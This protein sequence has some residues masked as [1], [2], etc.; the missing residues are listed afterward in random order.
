MLFVDQLVIVNQD[1]YINYCYLLNI[2]LVLFVIC[3]MTQIFNTLLSKNIYIYLTHLLFFFWL[4]SFKPLLFPFLWIRFLN[5]AAMIWDNDLKADGSPVNKWKL[6]S[7]Q[8]G[9]ELKCVIKTVPIWASA[10]H[11]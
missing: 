1:I 8:Q 2:A 6:C 9:E 7:V 5:K 11:R 3:Y 4:A 10:R